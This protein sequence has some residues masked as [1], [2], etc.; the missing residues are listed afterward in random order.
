MRVGGK[1][2]KTPVPGF[3]IVPSSPQAGAGAETVS[4]WIDL[5]LEARQIHS[6][7]GQLGKIQLKGDRV[8]G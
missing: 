7:K 8:F 3:T 4:H 6:L 5:E 2:V 1:H